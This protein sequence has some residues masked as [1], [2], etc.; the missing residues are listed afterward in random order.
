VEVVSQTSRQRAYFLADQ[1]LDKQRGSLTL[2]LTPSDAKGAKQVYKVRAG[3]KQAYRVFF[4]II[5]FTLLA[6]A[7]LWA[8]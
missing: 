8:A 1:W 6:Q 5:I 7:G 3:C 4:I 2:T